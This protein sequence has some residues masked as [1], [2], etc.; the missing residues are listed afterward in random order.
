[1]T[2]VYGRDGRVY[3]DFKEI[4]KVFK[5]GGVSVAV[6]VDE[7]FSKYYSFG[8]REAVLNGEWK[9]YSTVSYSGG[10]VVVNVVD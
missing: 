1:M 8:G 6:S 4:N 9:V 7:G 10:K 2:K 5:Q 3:S